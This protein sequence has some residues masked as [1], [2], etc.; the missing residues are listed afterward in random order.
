MTSKVCPREPTREMIS[1]YWTVAAKR[2]E[3]TEVTLWCAMY[4][5]VPSAAAGEV[6]RL[7]EAL[8]SLVDCFSDPH[9]EQ[10]VYIE[11]TKRLEIIAAARAALAQTHAEGK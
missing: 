5:A 8:Q 9:N 4:D 6:E 3:N 7:R 10:S 11:Y 1:A 2:D